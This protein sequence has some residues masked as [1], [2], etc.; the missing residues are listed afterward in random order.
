MIESL[1]GDA[2][3]QNVVSAPYS[4][5]SLALRTQFGSESSGLGIMGVLGDDSPEVQGTISGVPIR[6][7]YAVDT[8][9]PHVRSEEGLSRQIAIT[10]TQGRECTSVP[11]IQLIGTFAS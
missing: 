9:T 2:L 1:T 4:I 3:G 11:S 8:P 5:E 6:I 7:Q 10:P